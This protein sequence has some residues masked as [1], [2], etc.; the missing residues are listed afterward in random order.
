MH[1]EIIGPFPD[2]ATF[3]PLKAHLE[4]LGEKILL[5]T[6]PRAG[7]S[8]RYSE[9]FGEWT[10]TNEFT[11]TISPSGFIAKYRGVQSGQGTW[12]N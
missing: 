10:R 3:L 6:M 11:P 7:H 12:E 1:H 5:S 2:T 9:M 8:L 4:R